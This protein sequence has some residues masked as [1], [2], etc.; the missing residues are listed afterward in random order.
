MI[1]NQR[2]RRDKNSSPKSGELLPYKE[3]KRGFANDLCAP[4]ILH[5]VSANDPEK[6]IDFPA[7]IDATRT[8]NG[9]EERLTLQARSVSFSFDGKLAPAKLVTA[10]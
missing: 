5:K 9:K 6:V 7:E 8:R 3:G 10:R 1:D 4:A 2:M